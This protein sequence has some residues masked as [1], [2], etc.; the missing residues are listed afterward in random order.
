MQQGRRPFLFIERFHHTAK[1]C[2]SPQHIPYNETYNVIINRSRIGGIIQYGPG[3]CINQN[4]FGRN[5]TQADPQAITDQ[6]FHG[7]S[8]SQWRDTTKVNEGHVYVLPQFERRIIPGEVQNLLD[9][10]KI[11]LCRLLDK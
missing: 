8:S 2:S 1:Q 11:Q 6:K 7:R 3:G 9:T 5:V 4:Y 10:S